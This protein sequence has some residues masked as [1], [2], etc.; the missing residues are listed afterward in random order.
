MNNNGIIRTKKRIKIN[1]KGEE[2][3]AQITKK[4]AKDLAFDKERAKYNKRIRELEAQLKEK[5][6]IIKFQKESIE[7]NSEELY[8]LRDWITRLLE[9]TELSEE[10]MK[11]LI[12]KEKST[13]ELIKRMND[14]SKIFS[15]VNEIY[16]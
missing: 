2:N 14:M 11:K 12:D 9:Y 5:D 4:S 3:M 15:K 10:D 6:R 1:H 13:A 8:Q 16:L 7:S